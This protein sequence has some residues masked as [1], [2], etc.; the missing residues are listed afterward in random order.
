MRMW[1]VPPSKMCRKHLLGEHVEL[2]MIA[3]CLR[4]GKSI[5]GYVETGLI[6]TAKIADRHAELASEMARRGYNH[7]SPITMPAD[8]RREGRVS[9]HE[10]ARE[11]SRRCPECRAMMEV[12]K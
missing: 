2:H 1:M 4:L 12:G 6:E 7:K 3:A 10:S 8:V 5:R 9:V 11:L